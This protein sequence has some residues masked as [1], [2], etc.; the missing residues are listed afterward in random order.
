MVTRRK[1]QQP[2]RSSLHVSIDMELS[3]RLRVIAAR[4]SLP[5]SH[6]ASHALSH[7]A[8]EYEQALGIGR[9]GA[10]K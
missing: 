9:A 3:N 5:L 2:R 6:L 4:M 7:A 1:K 10:T 8:M